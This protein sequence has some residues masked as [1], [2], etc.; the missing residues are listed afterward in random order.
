MQLLF[1]YIPKVYRT[2]LFIYIFDVLSDSTGHCKKYEWLYSIADVRSCLLPYKTGISSCYTYLS[3]YGL[4]YMTLLL[5]LRSHRMFAQRPPPDL[6][7]PQPITLTS[8]C[9]GPFTV[10]CHTAATA[11]EKKNAPTWG[12]Q[13]RTILQVKLWYH[14]I[15]GHRMW[16]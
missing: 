11:R 16:E 14:A 7:S 6:D 15:I 5:G 9:S 1:I 13:W 3:S 2:F 8:T 10:G 12:G 4:L